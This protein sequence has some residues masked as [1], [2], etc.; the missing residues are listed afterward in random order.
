ME[1]S[2]IYV[3]YILK[4]HWFEIS[5]HRRLCW[6]VR[7]RLGAWISNRN[8][9]YSRIINSAFPQFVKETALKKCLNAISSISEARE[10]SCKEVK[11]QVRCVMNDAAVEIFQSFRGF[12]REQ[13]INISKYFNNSIYM[14]IIHH[15]SFLLMW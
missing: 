1:K 4:R 8:N 6:H 7:L 11:T 14:L 15:F 9:V 2:F 12:I 5:A 10:K 13:T 3:Y